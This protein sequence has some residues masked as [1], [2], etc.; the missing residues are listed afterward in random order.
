MPGADPVFAVCGDNYTI[1]CRCV[2]EEDRVVDVIRWLEHE[3]PQVGDRL[4]YQ[5][6]VGSSPLV[7]IQH[8]LQL[9][10][11]CVVPGC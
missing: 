7:G 3:E 10:Q 11:C 9:Q 6:I 1:I 5:D 2:L 8:A 4:A